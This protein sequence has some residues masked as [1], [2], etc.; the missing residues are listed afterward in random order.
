DRAVLDLAVVHL[1]RLFGKSPPNIIG[2]SDEMF[3]Q[4]LQL[5]AELAL[6]RRHH[7]DRRGNI[8]LRRFRGRLRCRRLRRCRSLGH[9][10]GHGRIAA[11]FRSRHPR[12]HDCLL[13]LSRIADRT[14]DEPAL[15]L[16]VVGRRVRK[17]ALE[18][19]P[20]VARQRVADHSEPRIAWRGCTIGP[21]ISNSEPRIAWRG[22]TIGPITSN[23]RPSWSKRIFARAAVT[24]AR[25]ISGLPPFGAAAQKDLGMFRWQLLDQVNVGGVKYY[26]RQVAGSPKDQTGRVDPFKHQYALTVLLG[27]DAGLA[28]N[29][30]GNE[31]VPPSS[32]TDLWPDNCTDSRLLGLNLSAAGPM[33]SL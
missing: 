10:R 12:R 9:R 14:A 23:R 19:V 32:H 21:I 1:A 2:V 18:C 6:L 5:A 16:T 30:R 13:D 8:R 31:H 33:S 24:S 25:S 4:F 28:L 3:A 7:G 11:P 20:L 27:G 15:D 29:F 26:V 22:C 17:P